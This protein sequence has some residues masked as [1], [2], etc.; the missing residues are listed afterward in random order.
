MK[1]VFLGATDYS[2]Q[3]LDVLISLPGIEICAIFGIPQKFK[4]SYRSHE[5][6]NTN[7][8][9]LSLI[10]NE[11][12]IPFFEVNS[13]EGK[14]LIDYKLFIKQFEPDVILLLGWYYM[15]PKSIRMLSKFGAWG[16]H[17]S[18]LPKYAGGAPL[19]WA[20][21]KGEK[22]TGV[23]LFRLADGVDDGDIISQ[24][25]I[26]IDDKDSIAEVY[27]KAKNASEEILREVFQKN[28]HSLTF[29]PQQK[30][31]LEIYPQ[32]GPEDGRIDWNWDSKRIYNFI[33]AQ[34]KP[35]P[36]AWTIIKEKKVTIWAASIEPLSNNYEDE[37]KNL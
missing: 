5:V 18:L 35:Y 1:I 4:I 28:L 34:S 3:L 29:T 13:V 7:F 37:T 36:G 17:A 25:T 20:I 6:E 32:R 19:V 9:D 8:A 14:R 27:K 10:A 12:K 22:N 2:K 15:V 30:G 16:I 31:I 21:I 24:K 26:V 33:R 23:T 11:K